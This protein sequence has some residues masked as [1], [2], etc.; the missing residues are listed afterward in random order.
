MA[1]YQRALTHGSQGAVNYERLEFL[2]DRVLG[3]TLAE[4]LYERFPGEPEGK[5]SRRFNALVTGQMCAQVAREIGVSQH[6][7]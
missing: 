1:L 6:L 7:K 2:G 3:L 5:L 4:W